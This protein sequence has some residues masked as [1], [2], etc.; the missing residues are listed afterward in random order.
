MSSLWNGTYTFNRNGMIRQKRESSVRISYAHLKEVGQTGDILLFSGNALFSITEEMVTN[1]P[2]SH[3]GMC[4]RDPD[5]G[6]LYNWESTRDGSIQEILVKIKGG[7]PRLVEL[8]KSIY[9]YQSEG[10]F[11]SYRKLYTPIN[12]KEHV[13]G[14]GNK[15]TMREWSD[16]LPWMSV[17]THKY[18]EIKLW[19]LPSAYTH[20]EV[21]PTESDSSSLFCSELIVDTWKRM[22]IPTHRK[23]EYY[24]PQDFSEDREQ[25]WTISEHNMG[26]QLSEEYVIDIRK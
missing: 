9:K 2:Y 21:I 1:S 13:G 15:L 8:Q 11:V 14:G 16:L 12:E 18:Y 22:K 7:G 26:Y 24:S 20:S 3:V 6:D 25:L 19:K 4:V 5:K 23:S 10:G 17:Q